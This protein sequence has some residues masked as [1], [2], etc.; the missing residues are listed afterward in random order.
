MKTSHFSPMLSAAMLTILLFAAT[1]LTAAVRT[2]TRH[3]TVFLHGAELEQTAKLS[4]IQ[5]A[6]EVRI[7][8]LAPDI[9][10]AGI[11]VSLSNGAVVSSFEYATDHLTAH[12]NTAAQRLR[13]SLDHYN[14]RLASLRSE[15]EAD[16]RMLQLLQT[17]VTNA[18]NSEKQPLTSQLIEQQLA[19][20][21]HRSLAINDQRAAH[22]KQR[23]LVSG[24]IEA[25]QK[26]LQQ[27]T[28][29]NATRS[30]VLTLYIMAPKAGSAVASLRYF[31]ARAGWSPIYDLNIPDISSAADL[32]LHAQV[33]QQ[34]GLD[35][36]NVAL[37]LSTG[38]PTSHGQLPVAD[39]WFLRRR[40]PAL[41]YAKTRNA[42]TASLF[43]TADA[44]E[45]AEEA[46]DAPALFEAE[47]FILTD[48]QALAVT[49]DI[50]LPYTILGNGKVQTVQLTRQDIP[51]PVYK[52]YTIPRIDS[53]VFLGME[54]AHPEQYSLLNAPVRITYAGTYYGQ[55][56]L[57]ATSADEQLRLS[58]GD[59][60]Q[61]AVKRELL[62][63]QTRTR[64]IGSN[65]SDTRTYRITLRNNKKLPATIRLQENYP[66]STAKEISVTL[67]NTTTRWTG[68]DTE[69]GLL[70]YDLTLQPGE[71]RTITVAYTV[72][73]PKDWNINL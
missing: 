48:E 15:L 10:P 64:L 23:D 72:K 36:T 44:L 20:Y 29:R 65:R 34:T 21:Q 60:P 53:R 12:D 35:W 70:T 25:L 19:Y 11:R 42:A 69:Q 49:Y 58:I 66:V 40:Q 22:E 37:T 28:S 13:D 9:D 16:E 14:A 52:Y 67:D 3:A 4:L 38:V 54:V 47:D 17:G 31:T 39:T 27:E 59:E 5:G 18:L 68:N 46:E 55:T 56:P 50:R 1:S 30:G 63:E 45:F 32:T 26:Q 62:A 7:E 61:I 33:S 24:R 57:N 43:M 51:T 71:S 2:E 6:N 41:R 73:Y 8:G